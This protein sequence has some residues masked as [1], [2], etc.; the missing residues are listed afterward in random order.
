MP[1][2]ADE[3]PELNALAGLATGADKLPY[4]TGVDTAALADLTAFGR[5]LLAL[6]NAAA[7]RA[8]LGVQ[9]QSANLDAIAAATPIADG[10]H[11]VGSNTITTAGGI[12]TA[13]S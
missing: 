3:Y 12:I 2:F 9:A 8:L 4:F 7:G 5:S 6:A 11:T 1:R 13:I 10:P